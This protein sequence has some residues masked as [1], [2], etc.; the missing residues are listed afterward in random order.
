M[1]FDFFD[2]GWSLGW[3]C[4]F[5]NGRC[6]FDEIIISDKYLKVIPILFFFL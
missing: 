1:V 4:F 3:F 5:Q 6:I 2:L